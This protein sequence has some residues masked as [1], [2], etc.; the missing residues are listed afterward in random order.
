MCQ[1]P[2]WKGTV[3]SKPDLMT[4]E[5]I[6]LRQKAAARKGVVKEKD[7]ST[8]M[9]HVRAGLEAKFV[10]QAEEWMAEEGV[11]LSP[12]EFAKKVAQFRSLHQANAA[13]AKAKKQA[14]RKAA[15][16]SVAAGESACE[17]PQDPSTAMEEGSR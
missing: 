1:R 3:I 14:E 11:E 4:P 7:W 13:Y 2:E 10:R 6:S 15:D 5:L 9:K 17:T 8:R 16:S 12:E